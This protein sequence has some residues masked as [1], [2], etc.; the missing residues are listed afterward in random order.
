[1]L[2]AHGAEGSRRVQ[3]AL[4]GV[5]RNISIAHGAV[6]M[7]RPLHG[8]ISI[9]RSRTRGAAHLDVVGAEEVRDDVDELRVRHLVS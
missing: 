4:M 2:T 7:L 1:M 8:N 6:D 5:L 3:R 9:A